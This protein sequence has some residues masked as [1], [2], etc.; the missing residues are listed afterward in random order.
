MPIIWTK[1][2]DADIFDIYN[3]IS[4]DSEDYAGKLVEQIY[5][6]TNYYLSIFSEIGR[7]GRVQDTREFLVRGTNYI[8]VYKIVGSKIYILGVRHGARLWPKIF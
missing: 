1:D 7:V 2:A 8:V 5:F 6:D 4:L 3:Y